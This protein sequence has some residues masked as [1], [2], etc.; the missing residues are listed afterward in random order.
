MEKFDLAESPSEE[1]LEIASCVMDTLKEIIISQQSTSP[2]IS[3]FSNG[4]ASLKLINLAFGEVNSKI[5]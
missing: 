3:H 2:V 4:E 5:T 1:Q